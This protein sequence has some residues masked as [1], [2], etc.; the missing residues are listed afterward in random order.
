MDVAIVG[1]GW[2]AAIHRQAIQESGCGR[3]VAAVG[4]SPERAG[5]T[6]AAWGVPW[7]QDVGALLAGGQ[8]VEAAW[9]C[10]PTPAHL[11]QAEALIA[12]GIHVVLEKPPVVSVTECRGLQRLAD[13]HGTV[14]LPVH[15]ERY[16]PVVE[17]AERFVA[18]GGLGQVVGGVLLASG[19]PPAELMGGWR[20]ELARPAGGAMADSGYHSLYLALRLLGRP[21]SVWGHGRRVLWDLRAE[22]TAHLTLLYA[23]GTAVDVVQSW[24][25]QPGTGVPRMVLWGTEATLTLVDGTLRQG[26]AI[27]AEDAGVNPFQVLAQRFAQLIA[28]RSAAVD[29]LGRAREVL[30]ISQAYARSCVSQAAEPIDF[31]D[32]PA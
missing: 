19:P 16:R 20:K 4:G 25:G 29:D 28:G 26:D 30:A 6:A 32:N 10:S 5:T 31:G 9:V 22:D 18:E 3:V 7:Y 2:V 1:P 17:A 23:D 24:A 12:A 27:V 13:A 8:A 14:V 15:N 11:A 21:R